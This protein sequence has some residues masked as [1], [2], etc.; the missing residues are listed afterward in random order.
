MKDIF[1]DEIIDLLNDETLCDDM[2]I[3]EEDFLHPER[4]GETSDEIVMTILRSI[5]TYIC[6]RRYEEANALLALFSLA[7][8]NVIEFRDNSYNDFC[9]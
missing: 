9:S 4:L 2:E 6:R 5:I 3:T 7:F 1:L 8:T